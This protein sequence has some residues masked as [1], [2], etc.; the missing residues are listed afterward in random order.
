MQVI[1]TV[2]GSILTYSF[3]GPS[4]CLVSTGNAVSY[5]LLVDYL[6]IGLTRAMWGYSTTLPAG[7][8]FSMSTKLCLLRN[9]AYHHHQYSEVQIYNTQI[10]TSKYE[11]YWWW[12]TPPTLTSETLMT[13]IVVLISSIDLP[14][15]TN[16]IVSWFQFP[17]FQQRSVIKLCQ[18]WKQS[19]Y[20][21]GTT[22][23]IM[24]WHSIALQ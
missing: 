1:V 11:Y 12:N 15:L 13:F 22:M 7:Q 9:L 18:A 4:A 23:T 5:Q 6:Q 8:G 24:L 14:R 19:P 21:Y 10:H 16:A 20:A 17:C 3:S 2:I